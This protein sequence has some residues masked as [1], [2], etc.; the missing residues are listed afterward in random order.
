[1][2]VTLGSLH[3]PPHLLLL[4][5]DGLVLSGSVEVDGAFWPEWIQLVGHGH[6]WDV[7]WVLELREGALR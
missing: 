6:C 7:L 2:L 4:S 5:L 1:M 3:L